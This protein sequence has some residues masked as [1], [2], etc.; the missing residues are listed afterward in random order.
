MLRTTLLA[1]LLVLIFG[2]AYA[3]SEAEKEVNIPVKSKTVA[4]ENADNCAAYTVGTA[5]A[6]PKCPDN[7][8]N[9]A[10]FIFSSIIILSSLMILGFAGYFTR[11]KIKLMLEVSANKRGD[12]KLKEEITKRDGEIIS[13]QEKINQMETSL[14][15]NDQLLSLKREKV[16][17]DLKMTQLIKELNELKTAPKP[18]PVSSVEIDSL[19]NEV[20]MLSQEK[21][22]FLTMIENLQQQMGKIKD[23]IPAAEAEALAEPETL[24]SQI[25]SQ[26]EPDPLPIVEAPKEK[27]PSL[28]STPDLGSLLEEEDE[29]TEIL[30]APAA[31]NESDASLVKQSETLQ[32][33]QN[34]SQN[35]LDALFAAMNKEE[36]ETKK[37]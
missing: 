22:E 8:C 7:S 16:E 34:F 21:I 29:D 5:L 9:A 10:S 37:E 31:E 18:I 36:Q 28:F 14:T 27:K 1:I 12:E 35:D 23:N 33:I 30:P 19:K 20:K 3:E 2:I 11:E 25:S 26:A 6:K 13:L 32:P 24:E 17:Q 4:L 15:N